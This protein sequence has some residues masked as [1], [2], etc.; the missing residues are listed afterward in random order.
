MHTAS[1]KKPVHLARG[2]NGHVGRK[3]SAR[4]QLPFDSTIC[5]RC[6]A[7]RRP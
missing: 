6:R 1:T 7:A 5:I 2:R 3:K 4:C